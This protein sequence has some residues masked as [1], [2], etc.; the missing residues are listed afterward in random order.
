MKKLIPLIA[1]CLMKSASFAQ[2]SF[3]VLDESGK[4]LSGVEIYGRGDDVKGITAKDGK[5]TVW[6]VEKKDSLHFISDQYFAYHYI[7]PKKELKETVQ[8]QLKI[9]PSA[10]SPELPEGTEAP[11]F[12]G[13]MQAMF[14]W[15]SKN[16]VY[17]QEAIEQGLQGKC[18]V[19]FSI[20]IDG[21]I[22]DVKVI[23]GVPYCPEC[24]REAIRVI[25]M[26]PKWNPQKERGVPVKTYWNLPLTFR[27][28]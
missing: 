20:D 5:V 2:I 15:I 14:E 19:R 7:A 16:M 11:S 27:M 10:V 1:A 21:S 23:R 24:D 17:P 3:L 22:S 18:Y 28:S 13:G 25:K 6:Q 26:M 8:I 4:P 9:N 12:P